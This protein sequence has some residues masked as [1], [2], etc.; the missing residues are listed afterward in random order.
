M[1]KREEKE[2]FER[3]QQILAVVNEHAEERKGLYLNLIKQLVQK[4]VDY[5]RAAIQWRHSCS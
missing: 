3:Y 2:A 5:V 1:E 4:C